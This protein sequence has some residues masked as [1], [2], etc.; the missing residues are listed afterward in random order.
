MK[1]RER[2]IENA[3]SQDDPSLLEIPFGGGGLGFHLM[4]VEERVADWHNNV[5]LMVCGPSLWRFVNTE[6]TL[7]SPKL[8]AQRALFVK[9]GESD[10]DE[11]FSPSTCSSCIIVC[12]TLQKARLVLAA[13]NAE[14]PFRPLLV[15]PGAAIDVREGDSFFFSFFFFSSVQDSSSFI[16]CSACMFRQELLCCMCW[17]LANANARA[18]FL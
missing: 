17:R 13:F 4:Q 11:I 10:G 2:K 15:H 14:N 7:S 3:N 16:A 12:F 18:G 6:T 1:K 8:S 5:A 9:L